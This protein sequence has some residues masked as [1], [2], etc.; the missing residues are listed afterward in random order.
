MG[1][2]RGRKR[3][4]SR[5]GD[6]RGDPRFEVYGLWVVVR[7]GG[8]ELA[9][10]QVQCPSGQPI[11][12][13]S[14]TSRGDGFDADAGCFREMPPIGAIV[15]FEET[16]EGIEGHYFFSGDDEYRILHLDVLNIAF[17]P[18]EKA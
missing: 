5:R 18:G 11:Q 13:G 12:Y 14:V 8:A 3:S 2:P 4:A 16:A 17:P 6:S 15:A 1:E 9:P 10:Y 7:M